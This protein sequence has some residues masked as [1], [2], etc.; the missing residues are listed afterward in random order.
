MYSFS[1]WGHLMGRMNN[2]TRFDC[3]FARPFSHRHESFSHDSSF[4]FFAFLCICQFGNWNFSFTATLATKTFRLLP[5]WRVLPKRFF[6][7]CECAERGLRLYSNLLIVHDHWERREAAT[8]FSCHLWFD[9]RELVCIDTSYLKQHCQSRGEKAEEKQFEIVS[10]SSCCNTKP[11]LYW[12]KRFGPLALLT[13]LT[14]EG[15]H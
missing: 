9:R 1:F 15:V 10:R 14:E 3:Q 7:P 2:R 13:E 5:P 4:F 6:E 11:P 8:S 12:I